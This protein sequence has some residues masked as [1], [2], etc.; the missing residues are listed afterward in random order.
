MLVI[1]PGIMFSRSCLDSGFWEIWAG[2]LVIRSGLH[3]GGFSLMHI[4]LFI[5]FDDRVFEVRQG[6]IG[7]EQRLLKNS[8]LLCWPIGGV[9]RKA[10][11]TSGCRNPKWSLGLYTDAPNS[12]ST[13]ASWLGPDACKVKGPSLALTSG[14]TQSARPD[15]DMDSTSTAGPTR[16]MD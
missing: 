8:A 15:K 6:L 5:R 10:V 13:E 4:H 14:A 7:F 11:C 3:S 16:D 2:I 9:C 12:V 1:L